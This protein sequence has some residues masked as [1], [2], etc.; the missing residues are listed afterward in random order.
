VTRYVLEGE[1]TG[2]TSRQQR[3]VHREIVSAKMAEQARGLHKIVYT[4]GTSL[5]ISVREAEHREKVKLA[6]QYND[7]IRDALR[8]G[9]SVV[10]V[11]DLC[12]PKPVAALLSEQQSDGQERRG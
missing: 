1:W 7:L 5:L 3:V 9:G 10:K 11:A 6:H 8:H 4:D 2:Y 12:E